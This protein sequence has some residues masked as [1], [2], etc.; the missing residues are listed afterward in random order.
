MKILE[1]IDGERFSK[2][3]AVWDGGVAVL[4]AGGPSLN[5][6]QV[7]L[8][9]IA[10]LKNTV[11]CIA[12]NDAYLL[13]EFADI[14]YFADHHWWRWHT[15]GIAMPLLGLRADQVCARWAAFAGQKCTIENSGQNVTDEAVHI[16]KNA[17]GKI[18]GVGLSSDPRALVTGRNSGFQALNLAILAGAK[19]VILLGFDG[20][21]GADGKTH[22]FGGHP[23]PTP[24]AA[25]P[26]YRQAMLAAVRDIDA[27]GVRVINCSPGSAIDSFPNLE[28]CEAMGES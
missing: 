8:V 24:S 10:H 3:N 27:T 15:D 23:R 18:H 14:S 22:W 20:R 21:V 7:E 2:V 16:L 6:E 11:H 13:A 1:R 28:L 12:V 26:L 5:A 19:K 25:Y 4:I 9:R 17:H